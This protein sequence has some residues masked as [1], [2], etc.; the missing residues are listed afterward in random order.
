ML[1]NH[2]TERIGASLVKLLL[3]MLAGLLL[4]GM[5]KAQSADASLTGRITDQDKT[6]IAGALIT[7]IN[8]GTRIHYQGLTNGTGTYYI[9]DLPPGLYRM[10]VEKLGFKTVIQSGVVLHVQDALELNFE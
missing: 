9:S 4:H 1:V 6:V 2:V 5:L 10:E 8:S 7:V 3:V